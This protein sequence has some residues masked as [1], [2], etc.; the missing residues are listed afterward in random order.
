MKVGRKI[1]W[2]VLILVVAWEIAYVSDMSGIKSGIAIGIALGII[3]IYLVW[4]TGKRKQPLPQEYQLEILLGKFNKKQ[5][6]KLQDNYTLQANHYDL[7]GTAFRNMEEY[8]LSEKAY[9]QAIELSP[10]FEDPYANLLSLYIRQGKYE[11]CEAIYRKGMDN[12]SGSKSSIVFQDGRLHFIKGNY[13]LAL[14][15]ARSI[16]NVERFQD[17]YAFVLAVKSMIALAKQGVDREE[18]YTEAKKLCQFGLSIFN[19]EQL[20]ELEKSLPETET[21]QKKRD[22]SSKLDE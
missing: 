22:E 2:T 3:G 17:E 20:R 12:S 15:A 11:Q 16:L 19:S 18:N 5:L 9:M 4:K 8:E 6:Q 13:E 1:L 21:G 7:I 14:H 10:G